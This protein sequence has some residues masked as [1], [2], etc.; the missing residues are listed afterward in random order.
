V[1]GAKGTRKKNEWWD[2]EYEQL[3]KKAVKALRE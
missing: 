1:N 3:K 2:Q